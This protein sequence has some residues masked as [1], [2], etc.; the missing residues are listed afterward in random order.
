MDIKLAFYE[1]GEGYP[2]ILLHGNGESKEYFEKQIEPFSK[3]FRVI[4]VDTRGHGGSPRGR[5]PFS[6]EQFAED[7]NCFFNEHSIEKA[8]ILGFSDGGN[9][10]LTFALKY[11]E[12][13]DRLIL[14]GANLFPS[15]MKL[16][17]QLPVLLGCWIA[18]AMALFDKRALCKKELL[19][20]M[21]DEPSFASKQLAALNMPVMII[22][23]KSDMIKDSH[24]RLIAASIKNSRLRIIEGDHFIAA[25]QSERFNREVLE[26]LTE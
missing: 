6:I 1:C 25:K 2:L 10:A 17:V 7:L 3:H 14:N 4:A 13:V 5:A 26:F 8:H 12:R 11:P 22:A 24:T 21:A 23:G 9:I 15:G 16:S 20:L 18:S 19:G